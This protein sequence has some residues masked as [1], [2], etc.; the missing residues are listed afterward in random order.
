M[1]R[2][3]ARSIRPERE[4]GKF[5]IR[6]LAQKPGRHAVIDGRAEIF[7][8]G[9]RLLAVTGDRDIIISVYQ[10]IEQIPETVGRALLVVVNEYNVVAGGVV[11]AAHERVVTP[12]VFGKVDDSN[13]GV[14]CRDLAENADHV[15]RRTVVDSDNL[16]IKV[17]L[18][19]N[20]FPDLIDDETHGTFAGIARNDKADEFLFFC[21]RH[22][23]P[24]G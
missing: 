15:V 12:A 18:L 2:R 3:V 23:S 13:F 17:G 7:E 16:V 20:D 6:V 11:A 14:L 9:L 1:T 10:R 19:R 5:Q 21:R 22:R 8:A 24:L 4:V